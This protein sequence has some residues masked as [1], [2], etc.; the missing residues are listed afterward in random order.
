MLGTLTLL[1]ALF[2]VALVVKTKTGSRICAICAAVSGTWIALLLMYWVGNY[3]S[4]LLLAILFGQSVVGGMYFG[5][6]SLPNKFDVFTLP[7][8]LTAT[9]I[10]Y[11]LIGGRWPTGEVTVFLAATWMVAVFLLAYRENERVRGVSEAVI[12]CCRDW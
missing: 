12:D 1:T 6:H 7:Y 2:V 10:G 11:V 5:K 9:A 4:H 8:V 3:Q